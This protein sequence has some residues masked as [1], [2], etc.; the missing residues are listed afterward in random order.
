MMDTDFDERS[1]IEISD[2][3]SFS[4]EHSSSSDTETIEI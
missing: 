2:D 1:T 4:S 3:S